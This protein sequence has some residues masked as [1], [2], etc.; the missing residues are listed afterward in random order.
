MFHV[1]HCKIAR[2]KDVSRET[3][4]AQTKIYALSIALGPRPF[5]IF[6]MYSKCSLVSL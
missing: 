2:K 1:K 5:G 6:I 4:L 3:S